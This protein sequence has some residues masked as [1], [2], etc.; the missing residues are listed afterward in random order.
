[1][2]TSSPTILHSTHVS[3]FDFRETR[4]LQS[5]RDWHRLLPPFSSPASSLSTS[6]SSSWRQVLSTPTDHEVRDEGEQETQR[7]SDTLGTD[8][9]TCSPLVDTSQAAKNQPVCQALLRGT[10]HRLADAG[11]EGATRS[12]DTTALTSNTANRPQ[13]D[14]DRPIYLPRRYELCSV[15]IWLS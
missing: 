6:P 11:S 9:P 13:T 15:E 10:E 3:L 2:L 1:M 4:G 14:R 8:V 7:P 12:V 5:V